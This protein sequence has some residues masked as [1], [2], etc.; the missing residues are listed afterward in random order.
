MKDKDKDREEGIEMENGI[1]NIERA[2]AE[3]AVGQIT[4]WNAAGPVIYLQN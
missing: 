1:A 3:E 2:G 4:L